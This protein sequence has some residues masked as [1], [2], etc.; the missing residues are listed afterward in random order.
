MKNLLWGLVLVLI[1][2][3]F[4][5][6][7]QIPNLPLPIGAGT[8]EVWRDTIYYFGGSNNWAGSVLYPDIY[9]FDGTAWSYHGSIPDNEMWDVESVLIGNDVYLL[10]GWP[11][12]PN[13]NRKYNLISKQWVYLANSPNSQTW[14]VTAEYLTG[15][16]YLFDSNGNVFAYDIASDQWS[17]RTSSNAIGYWDLSSILYKN[18]IYI[19]GWENLGFYKYTP[20]T[21]Q[22]SQLANTPYSVGASAMGIIND[23]IFCVGGNSGNQSYAQYRSVIVYD[24]PSNTWSVDSTRLSSR[25]H[26]MATA[27]YKGGLYVIGGINSLSYAVDIVEEIVPQGTSVDIKDKKKIAPTEFLVSQ[28]YPNP[29]NPTTTIQF[30][31]PQPA[32]VTLKIFDP[33]GKEI[34]TLLEGQLPA[35]RYERIWQAAHLPSGIYF[36]ELSALSA[37]GKFTNV[38]KMILTK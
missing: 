2:L 10:S 31:L 21:D 32:Q 18:E 35:G 17:N 11:Y 12:G 26:W 33:L 37:A 9:K 16:I 22:W 27:V 30:Q 4:L 14:G 36:Y 7:Q 34:E 23:S 20:A 6:S 13:F 5:P 29:F 28:N 25:R 38:K 3:S 24:I 15:I 8:A 19:I 1:I